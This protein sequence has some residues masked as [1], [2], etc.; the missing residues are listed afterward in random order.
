[1]DTPDNARIEEIFGQP[2]TLSERNL[3]ISSFYLAMNDDIGDA[4]EPKT[5]V[6]SPLYNKRENFSPDMLSRSSRT[7]QLVLDSGPDEWLDA[8]GVQRLLQQKGI[9]IDRGSPYS[10]PRIDAPSEFNLSTFIQSECDGE[11][12]HYLG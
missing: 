1:M 11:Y 12:L 7:W 5:K 10:S 6:L 3:L 4:I 9:H 8:S 2:L